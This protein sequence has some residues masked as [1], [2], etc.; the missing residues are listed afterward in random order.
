MDKAAHVSPMSRA[1]K[2]PPRV[3]QS[4]AKPTVY[5]DRVYWGIF[6]DESNDS[7]E[8]IVKTRKKAE[9]W[10][11]ALPPEVAERTVICRMVVTIWQLDRPPVRRRAAGP[12]R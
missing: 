2:A 10:K 8:H 12:R 5:S 1:S 4:R 11:D 3:M 7:P 9:N 6:S